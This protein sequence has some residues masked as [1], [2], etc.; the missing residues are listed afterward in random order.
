[1]PKQRLT[2]RQLISGVTLTDLLHF[3]VTGDTSQ[4]PAGS[5][6]KGN[7]EQL[8]GAFSA[9][10]CSNPLTVDVV[11]ACTS[12][13]TINGNV[14][15]NGS[16][17]T[18]NTEVIQSKDNNIVLNYS[19]THLTAIGGGITLEDGVSD[20]VDSKIFTNSDGVWLFDPGLSAS[21]GTIDTL[22]ACTGVYTSNLYGCS[23]LHIEPSGLNDVYVVENGGNVGIGTVTPN[24]KLD[25][26]G[27]TN[28]SEDLF[29][30][31]TVYIGNVTGT[32]VTPASL[33][34]R[35]PSAS[36]SSESPIIDI[37]VEDANSYFRINNATAT[38]G[39]FTP[40]ITTN[41]SDSPDRLSLFFDSVVDLT[42]DTPGAADVMRFRAR[43]D[44]DFIQNRD[45]Y[46]WYNY[47]TRLMDLDKDGNLDII[48]GGLRI[49]TVGGGTPLINLGLDSSGNVVTGTTGSI[50]DIFV[51]GG[52][53][54][55]NTDTIT[56]TNTSGGTFDV[57]GITDTFV[58]AGTFND[59][60]NTLSLLRND[61]NFV[62]VT[63]VTDTF[64]TGGTYS[65]GTATFTNSTGGTFDVTGFTSTDTNF[66]NTDLT[67][68]GNRNHNLDGNYLYIYD[69]TGLDGVGPYIYSTPSDSYV[70]LG[71]G[72]REYL[73]IGEV[74]TFSGFTFTTN[75]IKRMIIN[76]NG[77]VG[78]GT[79]SPSE[80]L[81]IN[82]KTKTINFQMTSGGTTGYVLSSID[83][84]GNAQW[85]NLSSLYTGNTSGTCITD[86]YVTNL[87]GCSPLHID[88]SGVNDVYIV[89]NGGNVGIGTTAT[90]VTLD[91][92]GET[93]LSGSGQNV[94]TVIGSGDTEPLF[95]VE[96]SSGEIFSITDSLVCSLFAVNDISG[97]PI[98]EVFD[99]DTVHMGSYQAPSLN[100]TVLLNPSTGLSTV[101]SIPMSAYTGAWFEYTVS[102]T[103]GARAGQIMSIFSGN[104]VNFTET[105][106]TDIGSTSDVTF[107]MSAD[108][109][110]TL[111]QVS[112]TTSGWEVKTIVRSI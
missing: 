56:F 10:T 12:G 105:T 26:N 101:Y 20:G 16:A 48:Q 51:T 90:T 67:F 91:V 82:G 21:T 7:V 96:G 13:I 14:V 8:F 71:H 17:T 75:S 89:E 84:D 1:M 38:D 106:T 62:N 76:Q 23:P 40:L 39:F 19:G 108:S 3:V 78:I 104:T 32:P 28:I 45:L 80:K 50:S 43:R 73:D 35:Q 99:D 42:Y 30:G 55:N 27:T 103:G 4:N 41:Q 111:L 33:Y 65:T 63:G 54:D 69:S 34:I 24:Y 52:T 36:S 44:S 109:T 97:L 79:T 5:S 47:T 88:P 25:V 81:H 37:Q 18:I 72:N 66:A 92:A 83:N 49:N 60:T 15:I 74:G 70:S 107:S 110:N 95:K 11:N 29:V 85:G 93:K 2:D 102:N 46:A 22:S 86:L 53:F 9:Y 31:D 87:Y 58:V 64:V 112:A 57:T 94:L 6:Y 98:L 61:G 77:N 100:T 59:T 68:T